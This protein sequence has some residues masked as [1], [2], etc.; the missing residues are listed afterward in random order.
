MGKKGR[1]KKVSELRGERLRLEE[2]GIGRRQLFG[3]EGWM[4]YVACAMPLPRVCSA[5]Q[6]T[7]RCAFF[8][9]FITFLF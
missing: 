3:F 1:K 8:M 6:D 4:G 5:R 9:S 2:E 7:I